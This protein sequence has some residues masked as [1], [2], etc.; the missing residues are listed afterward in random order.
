LRENREE[1]VL[2]CRE[3]TL[4]LQLV[5][6]VP[7]GLAQEQPEV[8]LVLN[9]ILKRA[10]REL[11]L[12]QLTQLPRFYSP[13]PV[14]LPNYGLEVWRGYS[15]ELVFK[16]ARFYVNIDFSSKITH[17]Q[18]LNEVIKAI[19]SQ[20]KGR[21]W[22]SSL[23]SQLKG[24]T[25]ITNYGNRRCYR[26]EDIS[27]D[28]T[29]EDTFEHRGSPM[30]FKAYYQTQ[31][32]LTVRDT[33]QPLIRCI[34]KS[35]PG[36]VLLVPELVSLTGL[37]D[38]M[39]SDYRLMSAI[40]EYTRLEPQ[41]RLNTSIELPKRCSESASVQQ[42][43]RDFSFSLNPKPVEI[44]GYELPRLLIKTPADVLVNAEGNFN[45]RGKI[46]RSVAIE[47]WIVMAAERDLNAGARL[48]QGLR[49]RL[50][51]IGEH[52]SAPEVKPYT[53][54]LFQRAISASDRPTFIVIL[55]HKSQ[56]SDY[57]TIKRATILSCPVLTQVV[58]APINDRRYTSILDK[59]A[60]QIQ[61]KA[62][63]LLW[64][65]GTPRGFG[66]YLMVVGLDVYHDTIDR[67]K[68]AV[69]FCATIH[70]QLAQYYSSEVMQASGQEITL[71]IGNLLQEALAVFRE[72]TKGHFPDSIVV[73]R[74]GVAESQVDCVK[75]MEVDSVLKAC[76]RM[77]ANYNPQ[78]IYTLVVKRIGTRFFTKQAKPGNPAPGTLVT[79]LCEPGSF[80]LQAHTTRQGVA[81]PTLYRTVYAAQP[82]E[83]GKLV[84]L[85]Y[86]LCHLYYNWMG[87]IK[88]PAPCMLAHKLAYL[89]GQSVHSAE[90]RPEMKPYAFYL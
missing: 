5:R 28:K 47:R 85:A 71:T 45:L 29:P 83:L 17:T 22:V 59:L 3:F 16:E 27:M 36:E 39:R 57:D 68:S 62:G 37:D 20:F 13:S 82:F 7:M 67:K 38:E 2:P 70:P 41:Q 33:N 51:A 72:R 12:M 58:M 8:Q 89:M 64:S 53:R 48:A 73:F 81:A 65:V 34:V 76:E 60:L 50:E 69:G 26:I 74:D 6:T 11:G 78:V 25:V 46:L 88:V 9:V 10:M 52:V 79:N 75:R 84:N 40:A 61:A 15:A 56:K 21:D 18:S 90:I 1:N 77:D 23:R 14:S 63:G 31:Y 44:Q 4:R 32:N 49:E 66:Q 42:L 80:Y 55:L 35:A 19:Y 86:G 54:D 43:F 24:R 87:A 30:T